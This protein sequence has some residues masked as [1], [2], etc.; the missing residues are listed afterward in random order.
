MKPRLISAK[1]IGDYR[2]SLT[3]T[4]GVSGIVDFA[5]Y[6]GQGVFK[7]WEDKAFF[8]TVRIGEAGELAWGDDIDFCGDALYLKIT[9]QTPEVLF[10]SLSPEYA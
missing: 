6:V 1:I 9:N 5:D 3:Y 10:S 4:D 8:S 7:C 2:V